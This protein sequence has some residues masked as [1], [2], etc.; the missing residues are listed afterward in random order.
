MR[1]FVCQNRKYVFDF[2]N[3]G[4]AALFFSGGEIKKLGDELYPF[5]P[6][7]NFYYL[8]GISDKN[9]ILY[10]EKAR[11]ECRQVLFTERPDPE[12][13]K[14]TGAVLKPEE[15]KE[16]SGIENIMFTDELN[17]EIEDSLFKNRITKVYLDLEKRLFSDSSPA[18]R[19]G[20]F[21]RK[22]YPHIAVGDIYPYLSDKRTVK[23]D[24][25]IEN[26]KKAIEITKNGIYAMMK[27]VRPGM[28][29]YEAEAYFDFELKRAGVFDKAFTSI[30]ASGINGAVLHYSKNNSIIKNGS[31]LL[32]D[33]GAAWNLYSGDITRTFPG[34]GKF[35]DRHRFFYSIVLEGNYMIQDI[36]KEGVPFKSL[37]ESLKK[38]YAKELKTIGL[39]KDS[40]DVSKYYWHNV[41]HLLGLE[42]HDAGRH[43]EGLLKEGMVLTVEPGLYIAEEEIGIRI[44]D[45]VLVKR[46]GC[47]NLSS[48]IIKEPE[49][50]ENFMK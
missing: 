19:F 47:V 12:K 23:A 10:M 11:G 7:R 44:E 27:N 32:C 45:D 13:E 3:D 1:E 15:A 38:Y 29:E 21:L 20:K 36:I 39:I 18:L 35:T 30:V 28:Y 16:L 31:L 33:V 37:N 26:I 14:W 6:D 5:A 42:T 46:D 24:F 22:S 49:D 43:N 25:E 40:S 17:S 41:S 2:L 48:D 8:T 50:I 34:G 4:E 9:I